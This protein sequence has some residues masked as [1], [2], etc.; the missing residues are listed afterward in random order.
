[1]PILFIENLHNLIYRELTQFPRILRRRGLQRTPYRVFASAPVRSKPRR[2]YD[3]ARPIPD[4]E[5]DYVPMYLANM[6]FR[7]EDIWEHL[8]ERL[9]EFGRA[10]GLF[11]E[12]SIKQLGQRHSEPFQV[13]I[14]KF[15]GPK[16]KGLRAI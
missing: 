7:K 2:T 11:D 16:K 5:G 15:G 1:M 6:F 4:S 14:R 13:Q 8:K 9:Q 12:I 3:P 10:A